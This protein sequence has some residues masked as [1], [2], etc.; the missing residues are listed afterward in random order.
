MKQP[1]ADSC[2]AREKRIFDAI[3]LRKA[4]RVPATA[5]FYFF[6]TH[7]YGYT[8]EQMM[9]DVDVLIESHARATKEFRPD[10]ARNPVGS[11]T[12]DPS[13]MFSIAGRCN[14]Y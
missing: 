7:Y 6:P 4:D 14:G 9:Y 1:G 13:S 5:S 11:C 2:G 10:L 3:E 12:W 8:V